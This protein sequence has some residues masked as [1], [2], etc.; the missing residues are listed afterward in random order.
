MKKTMIGLLILLMLT[1]CSNTIN[2]EGIY[3]V[4]ESGVIVNEPCSNS[5]IMD[6]ASTYTATPDFLWRYTESCDNLI[7]EDGYIMLENP[8]ESGTLITQPWLLDSFNELVPSWNILMGEESSVSIMVSVGN[9]EGFS[10]FFIMSLWSKDYKASFKNQEDDYAKV[11]IDTIVTKMDNV[12]R[13]KFKLVFKKDLDQS[14]RLKNVSITSKPNDSIRAIDYDYINETSIEVSPRQQLSIEGIGN[15]ICSP[16]SLSMILNYY[17]YTDSQS[18]VAGYIFDK[19]ANIY[20]NWSFNASYAGGF[21]DIESQVEFIDNF[22][23]LVDYINAQTP[24]AL[25]IKTRDKASLEGSIMA[26][27]SGHLVVLIG[28]EQIDGDWYALVND[29]AEYTD[30]N[31]LRKYKLEQLLDAWNGYTYIIKSKN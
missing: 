27:P 6:V 8:N 17:G 21:G 4:R 5:N 13:F 25:S 24:V 22:N 14:T 19:G 20:G 30:E 26:Y 2:K 11:Y 10:E 7:L 16:T 15:S 31:V 3:K 12:D 1:G 23:K 28:F 29:P 18:D 9:S